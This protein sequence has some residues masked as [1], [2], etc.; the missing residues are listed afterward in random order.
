MTCPK[1]LLRE[2]LFETVITSVFDAL[3]I[4]L[5]QLYQS[6]VKASEYSLLFMDRFGAFP[7]VTMRQ[8]LANREQFSEIIDKITINLHGLRPV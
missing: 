8:S 5:L 1:H 7:L 6:K 3:S 4:N 2:N